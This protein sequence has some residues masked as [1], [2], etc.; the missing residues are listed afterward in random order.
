MVH[1]WFLDLLIILASYGMLTRVNGQDIDLNFSD[2]VNQ[3]LKMVIGFS[4]TSGSV[5]QILDGHLHYVQGVA[6]DPLGHYVASL[7]S[8]R[9]CRIYM[10]KPQAKTKGLEKMNFVFQHVVSKAGQ[11][12][13]D[14]SKVRRSLIF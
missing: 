13:G 7:S 10:N 14:D 8:D 9:T 5:H 2:V 6:W 3:L 1:I 12:L 11:Q 4:Y